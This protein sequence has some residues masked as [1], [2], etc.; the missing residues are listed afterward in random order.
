MKMAKSISEYLDSIPVEWRPG[1]EQ[2]R[3]L[4]ASTEL[5]EELKWGIPNYTLN[6]KLI[7]GIGAF[8]S[9]FGI[10]FHNGAFLS[11]DNKVLI[12][13]QAG[14][15]KG[16][17][18]WRMTDCNID[19]TL[20]MSYILEAI[21]NQKDGKEIKPTKKK[22]FPIPHEL[23]EAFSKNSKLKQAYD[24]LTPFKRKEFCEYIST[25]KRETTRIN[26]TDKC[27]PMILAGI[28]LNDKYR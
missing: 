19:E 13:A 27:I 28:G 16:M 8:K 5:V 21:Q 10:W 20:V 4:F 14:K 2:L 26:R 23:L 17:R 24:A 3:S 11:D 6:K 7:A 12:N 22:A 15:T 18:Q 1:V 9:Y 25:A